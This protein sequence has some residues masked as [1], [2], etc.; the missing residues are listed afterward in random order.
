MQATGFPEVRLLGFDDAPGLSTDPTVL[1]IGGNSGYQAVNLAVLGG[2][3]R[4][5]L[6]GYDMKMG[7]GGKRH[8]HGDHPAALSQ[9]HAASLERWRAAF[10]SMLPD[11]QRLGVEVIN[12]TPGSAIECFP[13]AKLE[14]VI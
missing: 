14:D 13:F 7:P 3:N 10:P 9:F 1:H 6:A 8:W 4:I 11:L 2:A 12:C 5:L